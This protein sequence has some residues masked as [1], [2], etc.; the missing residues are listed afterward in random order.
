MVKIE[1]KMVKIEANP[2]MHERNLIGSLGGKTFPDI[3]IPKIYNLHH[4]KK[5]DLSLQR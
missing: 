4:E 2:I 1:G 5:V 3:D